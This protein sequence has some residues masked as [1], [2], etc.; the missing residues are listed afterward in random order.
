[1]RFRPMF[2]RLE[3][4]DTPAVYT[5]AQLVGA[6]NLGQLQFQASGHVWHADGSSQI[7][8]LIVAYHDPYVA[9]DLRAFD[10]TFHL[11]D[12]PLAVINFAATTNDGW[13]REEMLDVEWAHAVA[14]G[15][16]ILVIEARSNAAQDLLAAVAFARVQPLVSV[17][18]M[19]WASPEFTGMTAYN[20]Y[21]TTPLGHTGIT[22]VA[23]SGDNG[24]GVVWPAVVPGV[25]S[26]GG[27]TLILS[28][29][30]VYQSET[31]WYDSGGGTSRYAAG[32]TPT[33]AFD[34]DP[35]T[36][37][38][39]YVTTPSTGQAGWYALGGTSLGAPCWAGII[40]LAD[41]GRF[42]AGLPLL[43]GARQTLPA[44]A[45]LPLSAFHTV[46]PYGG[47][48]AGRGTPRGPAVFSGLIRA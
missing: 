16:G 40:A 47:V 13:A 22:Y 21:F 43:D 31:L 19:S 34:A 41:Q 24:A 33:V 17:I 35:A 1:M 48:T 37:V 29:A 46:V 42:R 20:G 8:A 7:I 15:A 26:V 27:T 10:R 14:P 44:L 5:P 38:Y 3:R 9:A 30:G 25:V 28:P 4:R 2:D 39:T 18:S 6:Y 11:P 12:P 45:R 32:T 23:A 36:G